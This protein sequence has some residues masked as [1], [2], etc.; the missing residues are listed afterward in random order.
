MK[1][2]WG[3]VRS[4]DFAEDKAHQIF[5]SYELSQFTKY[6]NHTGTSSDIYEGSRGYP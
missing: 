1:I 2:K 4:E 6:T 3:H 5:S